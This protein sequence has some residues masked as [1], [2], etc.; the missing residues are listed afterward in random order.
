MN[1][2]I[3]GRG[4]EVTEA[5]KAKVHDMLEKHEKLL[6]KANKIE[7]EV[8]QNMSHGGVKNDLSVEII[9]TMLKVFIRVEES[10]NDVYAIIDEMDPILRRR[11]VRFRDRI[12]EWERDKSWK[13]I[14]RKRLEEEIENMKEDRYADQSF[15]PP[16][17]TR[18]KQFRQNSPM[19]VAE[20]I[21]RMELL[22]HEA[23]LFKNIETNK[24][25][26]VYQRRDGTYGL[27]EPKEG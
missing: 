14:E 17:I 19:H 6:E 18:Y 12:K 5:I 21:E 23:F 3:T 11:L 4:V 1:I 13:I 15:V 26:V 7:V 9:V 20:A 22:G 10:G 25:S 27:I 8:K 2:I 24:Y 16:T